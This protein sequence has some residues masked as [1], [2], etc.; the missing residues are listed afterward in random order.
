MQG[1]Q[2]RSSQGQMKAC[3]SAMLSK[4]L[5]VKYAIFLPCYSTPFLQIQ[6]QNIQI[7]KITTLWLQLSNSF[8]SAEER[9]PS[10][11]LS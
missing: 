3:C 6:R 10:Q 2:V 9:E 7:T 1:N 11:Y 5:C 8:S 4:H